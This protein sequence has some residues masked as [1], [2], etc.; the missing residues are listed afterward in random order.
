VTRQLRERVCEAKT[1]TARVT[2]VA[3]ETGLDALVAGLFGSGCSGSRSGASAAGMGRI[4][5]GYLACMALVDV[6]REQIAAKECQR[7][8]KNANGEGTFW[9][10]GRR[11]A[12]IYTVDRPCL[13]PI[14]G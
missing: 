5:W 7:N 3:R 1:R 9:Q 6:S 4:S 12:G 14:K 2:P 11:S 10:T 8:D 13:G